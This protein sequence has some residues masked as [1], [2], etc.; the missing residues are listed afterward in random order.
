MMRHFKR[1]MP[2][3]WNFPAMIVAGF[4][5]FRNKFDIRITLVSKLILLDS[6][7]C[8]RTESSYKPSQAFRQYF[9]EG[10]G[11]SSFLQLCLLA[12]SCFLENLGLLT[13]VLTTVELQTVLHCWP[14]FLSSLAKS[15]WRNVPWT[16]KSRNLCI[17]LRRM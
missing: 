8:G 7:K 9:N 16:L 1:Q 2:Q 15:Y 6:E 5:I 13:R 11:D 12:R 3:S 14:K 17:R 10:H 4:I